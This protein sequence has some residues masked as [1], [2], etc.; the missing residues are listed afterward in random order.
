M[1]AIRQKV[2]VKYRKRLKIWRARIAEGLG[3]KRY[4]YPALNNLDRKM[5]ELLPDSGVFLEIGANDGYTQS[6]TYFLERLRNW[7]G[8]LIEPV[9]WLY[10]LCTKLSLIHI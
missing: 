1:L 9:P 2:P 4:S 3:F 10:E 8:I 6:N 7:D 5:D